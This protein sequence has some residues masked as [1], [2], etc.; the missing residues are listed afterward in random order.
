MLKDLIKRNLEFEKSILYLKDQLNGGNKLSHE[1]LLTVNFEK[2]QFFTLLP[3]DADLE[4]LYDFF[5]GTILVQNPTI[6]YINES[7]KKVSYTK[8][9]T[10][11]NEISKYIFDKI[12]TSANNCIFEDVV[13]VISDPHIDFFHKYGLKYKNELYYRITNDIA[14][15]ELILEAIKEVSSFWHTLFILTENNFVPVKKEL[16]LENIKLF[17]DEITL[18]VVGAYDGEGYVLWEPRAF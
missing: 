9:P 17:C 8:V 11:K 2:G 14:S 15:E 13:Q 5:G 18:L 4:H 16:T 3:P 7:G 12:K 6:E 1:L 10:L